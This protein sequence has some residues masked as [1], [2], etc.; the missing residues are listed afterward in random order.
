MLTYDD[1]IPCIMKEMRRIS[2]DITKDQD[3]Q[4]HIVDEALTILREIQMDQPPPYFAQKVQRKIREI[5]GNPDPYKRFKDHFN[6]TALDLYPNL[7][8]MVSD[9]KDPFH[10]AVSIALAGNIMDLA[11]NNRVRLLRTIHKVTASTLEI[12]H[13]DALKESLEDA[14]NLLYIGDN[15]GET[16]MDRLL[17][18]QFPQ[19][20]KTVYAVRGGPVINDATVEDAI[21]AGIHEIARV[22]SNGSDA[23]GTILEDCSEDFRKLFA[24]AECII[25]KGM[26]N[27]ETLSGV[28]HKTIFFLFLVKCERIAGHIGCPK[29]SA[30]VFKKEKGIV[31]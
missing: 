25:A 4:E 2:E 6:K 30:V 27:F 22:V 29:G 16:V 24:G 31:L 20:I 1:C 21:F 7:K 3:L 15:A 10:T 8:S 17:I 19:E 9:S 26:G 13:V 12:D 14:Q 5:S 11:T 18:E 28:A 23:P